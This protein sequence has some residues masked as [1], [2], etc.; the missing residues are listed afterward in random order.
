VET[1]SD[2]GKKPWWR[3]PAQ[4]AAVV[5]IIALI[6]GFVYSRERQLVVLSERILTFED[7][8]AERVREVTKEIEASKQLALINERAIQS[9]NERI[10]NDEKLMAA[11]SD[12]VTRME[13]IIDR[14]FPQG[15]NTTPTRK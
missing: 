10:T 9:V 4:I 11:T 6:G 5:T 3:N 1:G 7:R 13:A 8:A 2:N 12:R 15:P 14:I